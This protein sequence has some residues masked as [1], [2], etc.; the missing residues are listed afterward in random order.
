M[1]VNLLFCYKFFNSWCGKWNGQLILLLSSFLFEWVVEF[2]NLGHGKKAQ[3]NSSPQNPS[4]SS[5]SDNKRN[6]TVHCPTNQSK[7]FNQPAYH[8]Q[9]EKLIKTSK[10]IP[11]NQ[12]IIQFSWS[13]F[14]RRIFFVL[15]FRF[16]EFSWCIYKSNKFYSFSFGKTHA[17]LNTCSHEKLK[18]NLM[19][20][21]VLCK[22]YIFFVPKYANF[23]WMRRWGGVWKCMA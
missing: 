7:T 2:L 1:I 4:K 20:K 14:C 11:I 16:G 5:I 3:W 22:F 19:I 6:H 13:N 8:N 23:Q 12:F 17:I 9:F 18:C 21:S 15:Q 10:D